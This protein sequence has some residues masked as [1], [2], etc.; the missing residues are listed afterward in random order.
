MPGTRGRFTLATAA[1]AGESELLQDVCAESRVFCFFFCR[2]QGLRIFLRTRQTAAPEN[3][4]LTAGR[5]KTSVKGPVLRPFLHLYF[6]C[7][8]ASHDK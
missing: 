6:S 4:C 8:A 5:L 1:V 3:L 7:E 2:L